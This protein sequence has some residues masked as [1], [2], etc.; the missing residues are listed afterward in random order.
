MSWSCR[1]LR[2][3]QHGK[4]AIRDIEVDAMD[5]ADVPELLFQRDQFHFSHWT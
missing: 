2:A 5:D 3:R 4:L 1:S